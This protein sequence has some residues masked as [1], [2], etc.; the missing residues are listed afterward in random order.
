MSENCNKV[1]PGPLVGQ[2]NFKEAVCINTNKV[3]DSC[4]D[5][6]CLEDLRVYL[7]H[8][9]Q[10]I[11]DRAINVR[12]RSAE[13]IWV[14]IDVEAVP[15]NRGF[16]TVD[17]KYFFKVTFDAFSGV[18]R[19]QE[20]EGLATFDKRVILFGSEGNAKVFSSKFRPGTDDV[21][22]HS[23]TNM[24]KATVETVDPICLGVKVVDPGECCH[25]C[26]EMDIQS[27]PEFVCKCFNDE[28]HQDN[29]RKV[30]LVTLGLFSIVRIER[31][32]QLLIPAFDFCIPEKECI[33]NSEGNPCD[34]FKKL[35]FPMDEFFPPKL[36]DFDD[37]DDFNEA[38]KICGCQG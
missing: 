12:C 15:F 38:K 8:C 3:Y 36:S 31:N 35:K 37:I 32:V 28:F 17:I 21:Q 11:V 4:R 25:C 23:K 14:Y 7:T 33:G 9:S 20:V 27:A 1:L 24:P 10:A 29:D 13:I 5:K 6:D 2:H 19:P 26:G 34:L 22:L 30:L 16:Y 18:C